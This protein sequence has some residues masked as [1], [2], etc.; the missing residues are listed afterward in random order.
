MSSVVTG[1][2]AL[3]SSNAAAFVPTVAPPVPVVR[4]VMG[5]AD[6]AHRNSLVFMSESSAAA[7]LDVPQMDMTEMEGK[8]VSTGKSLR[9]RVHPFGNGAGTREDGADLKWLLG[10][11]GANLAEMAALGLPV[12]AG[13]TMT[14][15]VCEQYHDSGAMLTDDIWAEAIG[16]KGLGHIE[17]AMGKRLG[18]ETAPLLL[19]VR[20]GAAV[21]MPGM[22]DTVLN[23]GL[24]DVVVKAL[25]EQTGNPRFAY[26]SYR[27]FLDMFGDVV[28]GIPH[29][30][31]EEKL[32]AM[33]DARGVSADL[34]LTADDLEKL[35]VQYKEVYAVAG[36]DFPEEP[37]EQ[38]R[39][40]VGA[41]FN[42]WKSERAIK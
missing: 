27:R 42:S 14:T 9:E 2:L 35:C 7:T 6:L 39:L 32:V 24:N 38:L 23:L 41:V 25:A 11:K 19:S 31:F 22:M 5:V 8:V 28:L 13:F 21:S 36:H 29:E 18:D 26:D 16:A 30:K 34:D 15:E 40:A 3:L 12:P 33:R 20:S 10:G 1:A 37:L 17:E 4:P